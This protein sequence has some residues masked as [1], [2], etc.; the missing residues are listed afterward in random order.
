MA[1]TTERPAVKPP[2]SRRP[3]G[4]RRQFTGRTALILFAFMLPALVFV[5]LFTYYL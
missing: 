2:A 3:A 4:R 1:V 5:G